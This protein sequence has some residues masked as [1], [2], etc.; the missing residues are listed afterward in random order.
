MELWYREK[1][2]GVR[3]SPVSKASLS[4]LWK[5]LLSTE[6]Y[7]QGPLFSGCAPFSPG[8]SHGV[9]L[10]C[11]NPEKSLLALKRL[12]PDARLAALT[13]F[14]PGPNKAG[15]CGGVFSLCPENLHRV[16]KGLTL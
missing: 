14:A 12:L 10:S 6:F 9:L 7:S 8:V 5:E 13:T 15:N 2:G 16:L 11:Q 3:Q 1:Q 4:P